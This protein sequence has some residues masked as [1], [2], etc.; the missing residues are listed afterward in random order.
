MAPAVAGAAGHVSYDV[1]DQAIVIIRVTDAAV[2]VRTWD[3]NVVAADWDDGEQLAMSKRAYNAS[4]SYAVPKRTIRVNRPDEPLRTVDLPPEDFPIDTLAPGLHDAVNF[5][6]ARTSDAFAPPGEPMRL[7]VTIPSSTG[8][9]FVREAH[10]SISLA[11][12][13]GTAL[14]FGENSQVF[15]DNVRGAMFLQVIGGHT[16]AIDSTF[17]RLRARSNGGSFVFERCTSKQIDVQTYFGQIVYDDGTF[18]AGLARF[19]SENGNIALGSAAPVQFA[20]RSAEGRVYSSFNGDVAVDA[21]VPAQANA[22]VGGGGPLVNA[23]SAR[24]NVFFYDGAIAA[25]QPLTTEWRPI[26]RTILVQRRTYVP[27]RARPER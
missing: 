6:Q 7:T 14:I 24:G 3:R 12:Y 4:G 19:A 5:L 1:T 15:L 18:H 8:A 21:P 2:T 26:A 9:V 11:N 23:S 16:Y 17:D 25:H 27:H 20:G 13:R 10:G 22:I